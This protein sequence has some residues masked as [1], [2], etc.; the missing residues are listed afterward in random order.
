[1]LPILRKQEGKNV[2][3][4]DNLSSHPSQYVTGTC[5]KHNIAFVCLFPNATHFFQP[6]DVA[7]C[8]PLKK[9]WRKVLEDWIKSPKGLKHKGTLPKEEFSNLLKKLVERFHENGAARENLVNGFRKCGLF[10]FYPFIS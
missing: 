9:L 4:G 2:L 7:W 6:L 1:M 8:A 5:S 3:I 10:P